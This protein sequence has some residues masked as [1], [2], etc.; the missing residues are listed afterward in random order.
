MH[1]LFYSEARP[2]LT[3]PTHDQNL[4]ENAGVKHDRQVLIVEEAP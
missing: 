1:V 4:P 2:K 3:I